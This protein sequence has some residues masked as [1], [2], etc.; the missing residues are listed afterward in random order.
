MIGSKVRAG[1]EA[2]DGEDP[3]FLPCELG[4][5]E[6][7]SR[8]VTWADFRVSL[9][10]A[11]WGQGWKPGNQEGGCCSNSG[12]RKWVLEQDGSHGRGAAA[13]ILGVDVKV[14]LIRTT[15]IEHVGEDRRRGIMGDT[16]G[17]C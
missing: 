1:G 13:T 7:S 9:A 16:W 4:A 6:V 11:C 14:E 3:A 5:W 10:E 12:E 2:P 15:F 8:G 17:V